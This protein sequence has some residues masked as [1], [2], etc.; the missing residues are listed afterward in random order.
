MQ[1]PYT[2]HAQRFFEQ[3]QRLRF[4]DVHSAWLTHLPPAGFALD[5]GAGSGRDAAAL[6]RRGWEVLAVEPAAGLRALGADATKGLSVQWLDDKLPELAAVRALSYRFNLILVS[7]VWMHL[8]PT[9]RERAFRILAEL[10]APGGVLV[11]SLRH[12]AGDAER[13]FYPVDRQELEQSPRKRALLTVV[14]A[15]D[16]DQLLRE[17]VRW[18]TLV[19]R[20]P[21]DGTGALPLLRHVIVNDNKASTYKLGLLR[22]LTRI[23]D[24]LPG[25]ILKRSDD[26]VE[27]PLGLVALYW[28]KLYQPLVLSHKLRQAPGSGGYGF[29]SDDFYALANVSPLDLRVGRTLG[30]DLGPVV[31]RAIRAAARN[32][33]DMPVRYTSWPAGGPQVFDSSVSATRIGP[34]PARLDRETLARFGTFRVPPLLWDCFSRYACWLEPAIVN[35]WTQLMQGYEVR[36]HSDVYQRALAWEEGRRDTAQVRRIVDERLERN[37]LTRCV[38]SRSDLR[39]SQYH[40]DHC[41]PWSRW[42]N[43]DLWNLLPATARANAAK[44]EKLPAAP[45]LEGAKPEILDWWRAAFIGPER[46][47]QFYMEAEGALPLVRHDRTLESVFEGMLQ[48]RLRLKMNQQL[49]E[50]MGFGSAQSTARQLST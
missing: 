23:A 29:A 25:M 34:G 40:I 32:I 41:F 47:Q 19:F 48:Q 27:L 26:W 4:E 3:Y 2:R 18:E 30:G 16:A 1:D 10:L 45:L 5:V 33:T 46:E 37:Q 50:W 38:W 17:G 36:D 22:A 24:G 6:A 15:A 11:I 43:N 9:Q 28:I 20:L 44:A 13:T 14:A 7:A 8:P 35:E 12:G 39:R 49:A 42:N 31:L 21:D